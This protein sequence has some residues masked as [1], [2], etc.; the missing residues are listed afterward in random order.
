MVTLDWNINAIRW[1]T[2]EKCHTDDTIRFVW[3]IIMAIDP[4]VGIAFN[5]LYRIENSM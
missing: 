1:L 3:A 2:N 4:I 5:F